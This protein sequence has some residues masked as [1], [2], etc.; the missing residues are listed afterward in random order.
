MIHIR[1]ILILAIKTKDYTLFLRRLQTERVPSPLN[2]KI[3]ISHKLSI[4]C[5]SLSQRNKKRNALCKRS[6]EY[7]KVKGIQTFWQ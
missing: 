4:N 1:K 2:M 7:T 3:T 5:S 6:S